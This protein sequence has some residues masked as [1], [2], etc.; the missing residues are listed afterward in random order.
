MV[1]SI[2][3][4][5]LAAGKGTR[6]MLDTPKPLLPI[7]GKMLIDFPIMAAQEFV[8][9]NNL[10][11]SFSFVLGHKREEVKKHISEQ[12]KNLS[13]QYSIQDQQL[14]TAHA[15]KTYF[16]QVKV[17][18]EKELTIVMCADTP[19]MT[20][21]ELTKL[22]KEFSKNKNLK[23]VAG[24]FIAECPKGYG[25]IIRGT[26]GF[27]IVEEKD[28]NESQKKVN[29]VN[30]GL[31]IC[32]TK[33]LLEFFKNFSNKNAG[34]EFY[35]TDF[36]QQEVGHQAIVCE[37]AI[38]FEGVNTLEQLESTQKFLQIE[39]IK[40]LQRAGVIVTHSSTNQI[41]YEVEV[42]AGCVIGMGVSL[43][44]KT[45]IGREVSIEQGSVIKNSKIEDQANILAYSYI[46][47]SN[48]QKMSTIGPFARIR[49]GSQIGEKAKIGN[50]V[51][52]KKSLIGEGAKISHLSYV[53][54]AEVG[55]ES[56]I[57]C[58][59][60]TC[61]YDGIQKHKTT[62]G[63]NVFIGSDCQAIAPL[64]IGDD[65]FVAAGTTITKEIPDGAFAIGRSKQETKLGMAKKFLKKK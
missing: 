34:G 30:S 18:N 33:Y 5:F 9:I 21:K 45:I 39:K 51:E 11:A 49:P 28:A 36:F 23:S 54:D 26:E 17:A 63:K 10:N 38:R 12:Y 46:E 4:V 44:G 41:D 27:I 16:D 64:T 20:E 2:G 7:M 61:N 60:I 19:L 50:F 31:Y 37:E 35:L 42:S 8:K 1:D 29:E 13:P 47:D 59:F 6:L 65:S 22:F 48:I 3:I 62:I 40:K 56:N 53:G 52:I 14:G 58:G 25:R 32:R 24:T 55:K 57:G 15:L 43:L